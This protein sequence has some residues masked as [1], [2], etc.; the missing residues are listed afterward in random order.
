[1]RGEFLCLGTLQSGSRVPKGTRDT[2]VTLANRDESMEQ[3]FEQ[4]LDF[5]RREHGEQRGTPRE[6]IEIAPPDAPPALTG[7]PYLAR[8]P[9]QQE[10]FCVQPAPGAAH[11]RW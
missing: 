10:D 8:P 1:M 2:W 11:A 9:T 6:V 3:L 4:K 5:E 7:N